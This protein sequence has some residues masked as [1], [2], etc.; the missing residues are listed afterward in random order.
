MGGV[1]PF[2]YGGR[3]A[4]CF[5]VTSN[6]EPFLRVQKINLAKNDDVDLVTKN[7]AKNTELP[8]PRPGRLEGGATFLSAARGRMATDDDAA[9]RNHRCTS[10]SML[11][12]R[13]SLRGDVKV[14]GY[15]AS[16]GVSC[17]SPSLR[18]LNILL[19]SMTTHTVHALGARV[20]RGTVIVGDHAL[21]L[22]V[23]HP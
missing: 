14:V 21:V 11:A 5:G 12:A 22:P 16:P 1:A 20:V 15:L 3:S 6:I 2:K 23:S 19:Q 18:I 17:A 13:T 10:W 4:F 8:K 7:D 9:A